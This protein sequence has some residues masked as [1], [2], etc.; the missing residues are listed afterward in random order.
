VGLKVQAGSQLS[1]MAS[2]GAGRYSA[3]LHASPGAVEQ[4]GTL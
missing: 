2:L 3:R 1:V 4:P